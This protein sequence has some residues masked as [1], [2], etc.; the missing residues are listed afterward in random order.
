MVRMVLISEARGVYDDLVEWFDSA[1]GRAVLAA[2]LL[3]AVYH[4]LDGVRLLV[5]GAVPALADAAR[6]L[7]ARGAVVFATWMVVLPGWAIL[8]RPW[9]EDVVS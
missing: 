6:G 3:A 5:A 4:L 1:P 2:V 8:F 9:I 7:T